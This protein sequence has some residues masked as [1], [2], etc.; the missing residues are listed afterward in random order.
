VGVT[1]GDINLIG[2]TLIDLHMHWAV[3]KEQGRVAAH[4]I[5][6]PVQTALTTLGLASLDWVTH[7]L[8]I[9][10]DGLVGPR[11]RVAR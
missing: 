10:E 4:N 3:I 6:L 8:V 7:D 9:T 11:K 5:P 2:F 1:V